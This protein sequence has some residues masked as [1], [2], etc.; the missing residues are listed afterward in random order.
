MCLS[1]VTLWPLRPS[2]AS[3]P[4]EAPPSLDLTSKQFSANVSPA[5]PE[6][7]VYQL[8]PGATFAKR[9][10]GSD[11]NPLRGNSHG[12]SPAGPPLCLR[13]RAAFRQASG[14]DISSQDEWLGRR[15]QVHPAPGPQLTLHMTLQAALAQLITSTC[16]TGSLCL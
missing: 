7:Q 4:F 15:F 10:N 9:K 16:S 2:W 13:V 11:V 5:D 14:C 8:A 6:H 3:H 1:W 12:V